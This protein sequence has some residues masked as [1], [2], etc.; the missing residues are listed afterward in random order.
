MI[1]L[2]RIQPFSG[3]LRMRPYKALS[4]TVP[5]HPLPMPAELVIPMAQHAGPPAVPTVTV[6]EHVACGQIIGRAADAG[7]V[8]V[9]ASGSGTVT[10][11]DERLVP[12]GSRLINS[13]CA[14]IATD[15]PERQSDD[16][17]RLAW[18]DDAPA[19]LEA[20]RNAGLT[21]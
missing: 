3:G 1:E 13:L 14:I 5:L 20:I 6:G 17:Q 21:G 15:P 12:S 9:H 18:P 11:L 8:A 19:R 16:P 4:T 10:A 2:G 7:S